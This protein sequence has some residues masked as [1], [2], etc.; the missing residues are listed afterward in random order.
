[1]T[2][3]EQF[4]VAQA[5]RD[6]IASAPPFETMTITVE[7]K[8]VYKEQIGDDV[9]YRAPMVPHPV[10]R[11]LDSF[12][13]AMIEIE[14]IL[15]DER[16]L[17]IHLVTGNF[18]DAPRPVFE[19]PLREESKEDITPQRKSEI[20]ELVCAA[21]A[22]TPLPDGLSLSVDESEIEGWATGNIVAW[23]VPLIA[24]PVP[25]RRAQLDGLFF[26]IQDRL[27][28]EQGLE[29]LL[30]TNDLWG[31]EDAEPALA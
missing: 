7:E 18:D 25:R 10:P 13:D 27:R 5:V 30:D 3:E 23:S 1:M 11:R 8:R 17:N 16:N 21:I 6:A 31:V 19:T 4:E 15:Q 28:V 29:I 22:K 12:Y 2:S 9:W 24:A 26:A 20:A 14:M